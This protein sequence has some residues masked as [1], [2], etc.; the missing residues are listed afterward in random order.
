[1][2]SL[3]DDEDDDDDEDGR[4]A[5]ARGVGFAKVSLQQ[6]LGAVELEGQPISG[7]FE[8]V[9]GTFQ[10]SV[11]AFKDGRFSEVLVNYSTGNIA[12]VQPIAEGEDLA[13]AQSQHAAMAKAKVP[14]KEAVERTIG[15][16]TDFRAVAV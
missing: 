4:D 5:V 2:P 15:E 1:M 13:I 8:V 6:G 3:R 9:R 14:L 11:Y 7:K 16:A 10:L 12:K